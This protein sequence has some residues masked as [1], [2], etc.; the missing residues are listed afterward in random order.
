MLCADFNVVV[1][2]LDKA[3]PTNIKIY[4]DLWRQMGTLGRYRY[5]IFTK[6]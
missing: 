6:K 5:G 4:G 3:C 1:E 2:K